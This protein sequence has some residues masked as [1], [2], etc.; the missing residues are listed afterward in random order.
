[1]RELRSNLWYFCPIGSVPPICC[2][3][4]LDPHVSQEKIG[5]TFDTFFKYQN[6]LKIIKVISSQIQVE[7]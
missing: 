2:P 7:Y 6:G 5:H 4:R 3:N 1:M